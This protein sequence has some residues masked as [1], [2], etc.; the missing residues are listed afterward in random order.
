MLRSYGTVRLILSHGHFSSQSSHLLKLHTAIMKI[1]NNSGIVEPVDRYLSRW[2][3]T[4]CLAD[5][6]L[7]NV[8]NLVRTGPAVC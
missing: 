3:I 2:G 1:L 6:G 8:G 4:K 5:D 7:G